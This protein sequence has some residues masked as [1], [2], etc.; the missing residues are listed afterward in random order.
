MRIIRCSA[1]RKTEKHCHQTA[2]PRGLHR[3]RLDLRQ[4]LREPPTVGFSGTEKAVRPAR[5]RSHT[6]LVAIPR[7]KTQIFG[8]LGGFKF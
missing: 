8:E 1:S 5:P 3:T 2:E 7:I 6:A 4:T